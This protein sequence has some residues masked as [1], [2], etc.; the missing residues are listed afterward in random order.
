MAYKAFELWNIETDERYLY[1]FLSII[2]LGMFFFRRR[3][4]KKYEERARNNKQQ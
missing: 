3:F 2:A 1:L 4:F